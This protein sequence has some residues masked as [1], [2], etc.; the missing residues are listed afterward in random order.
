MEKKVAHI[1]SHSHWDREWYM[2]F[3]QHRMKLVKLID[4]LLELFEGDSGFSSFFLDGQTI[5]LEDYLQIR[6]ENRSK[7]EKYI[8]EGRLFVGP[9]YILQDEFLTSSESNIRNLLVGIKQAEEFGKVSMFGYFPDAFGNA[10]QMPQIL[11]QAGMEAAFFGRGVKPVGFDNK[12]DE[13]GDYES[14]F[15]EMLWQSPDGSS[16][17]GVLFANWYCNGMEVPTDEE[18]AKAYWGKR[19]PDAD[20]F[21]SS[22]HLLFM[23]GCDHQPVQKDLPQAI[24]TAKKL[25]PEVDFR[26]SSLDAF[27][28]GVKEAQ[29]NKLSVVEG[30]LTSQETDGWMTLVNT[31][32]SRIYLKQMNQQAQAALEKL[33]EPLG[34]MAGTYNAPWL[35]YSWKTLM[36][37][38]PHDSIC[39]CSVDEVHREMAVRF[40]KSLQVS[41][42]LAADAQKAL[43]DCVD[44]T[45]FEKISADAV[46]IVVMNTS[47]WDRTGVV[48]ANVDV[49][50]RY[51]PDP[52]ATW[53][54]MEKQPVRSWS[55]VDAEGHAVPC[56]VTYLGLRFDYDLPENAFR[57]PYIAQT[58]RVSFEAENVPAAGLRAYALVPKDASQTEGSLVT[59][60]NT[61]E[62]SRLRVQIQSNGT[63]DVTLKATDHT[64]RGLGCYE[65]TGDIGNEYIYFQPVGSKPIL[66]SELPAQIELVTDTPYAAAFEIRQTLRVP[67]SADGALLGEQV[68]VT[69]FNTR[70]A[71]RSDKLVELPIST[72][73]TLEKNGRGVKIRSSFVNQAKDHRLRM[74]FPT[75]LVAKTHI[76]DSI[77]EAVRRDNRPA[78]CW[79]NPSNCQH[80]QCFASVDDGANGLTIANF[81]LNEYEVLPENGNAIAVTLLRAVGEMGDWGYFPTPE[82]QCLGAHAA[83]LEIIPHEGGVAQSGAFAEAYQFQAAI[84]V[85]QT[86]LH[87]GALPASYGMFSYTGETLALSAIKQ[88]E[89]SGDMVLRWFNLADAPCSL[90]VRFAQPVQA[91]YKSNVVEQTLEQVSAD[92]GAYRFEVGPAEIFTIRV[93]K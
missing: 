43:A 35:R 65:E 25:F 53:A 16:L 85:Q 81:G 62:N 27:V 10:G 92:D 22:N 17:L 75:G 40:E 54:E 28:K 91:V 36:Q 45:V 21:A 70:K 60:E 80:Q 23:N 51:H 57:K 44:T 78:P 83:E 84:P 3:E 24:E 88:N 13:T 46:P 73:V 56:T 29:K 26:H 9:W 52:H 2:S 50:R 18:Q 5:A 42:E 14:I 82:A 11:K 47:G 87:K 90:S 48:T 58:V 30:E 74:L 76:A 68:N 63:L 39:G 33:A 8:Q 89:D 12:V 77:F 86:G 64:Y 49:L 37:N 32:S 69:P 55:V 7:L 6:P 41:R 20:K 59:G 66:S 38:H 72:T 19:I 67:E 4:D 34:V 71:E 1:V 31:C 15:S 93:Q 79:K 61:M